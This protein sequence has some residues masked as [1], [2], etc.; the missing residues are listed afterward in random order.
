MPVNAFSDEFF[1]RIIPYL[2][3]NQA[4][5]WAVGRGLPKWRGQQYSLA[6]FPVWIQAVTSAVGNVVF[7]RKLGCVVT[8]KTRQAGASLRLISPQLVIGALLII[9]SIYGGA[10]LLLGD[11]DDV[12][13]ILINI[14]WSIYDLLVLS[15][16]LVAVRYRPDDHDTTAGA[17]PAESIALERGRAGM[18]AG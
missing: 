10:R 18:G 8:P 2:L 12:V 13:A 16:L 3:V 6:L 9:A 1:W 11:S 5:F 15:I 17:L 7:K 4:L 14:S